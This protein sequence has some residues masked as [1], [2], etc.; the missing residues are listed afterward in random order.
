MW[1]DESKKSAQSLSA[2]IAQVGQGILIITKILEELNQVSE[3]QEKLSKVQQECQGVQDMI[4]KVW[5][6]GGKI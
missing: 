6:R 1:C 2:K 3:E 4:D 5:G